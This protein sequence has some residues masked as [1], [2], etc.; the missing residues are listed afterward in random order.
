MNP[1]RQR[2]WSALSPILETLED[3]TTVLDYGSGDG[4]FTRQICDAGLSQITALEVQA[5]P[6][7]CFEPQLF[8]GQTIP[9]GDGAFDLVYS[10]D[11][12]HHCPRPRAQLDELLRVCGRYLLLK[13]H[14]YSAPLGK[15]ALCAM[16]ELGNRRFGV[17]SLYR[18]QRGWEWARQIERA[19]FGL[20]QMIH[21][22]PV[23]IGVM[24]RATNA[25]QWIGLWEKLELS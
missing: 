2:V 20:R 16:D 5:R 4:W 23:H 17:P 15:L 9:F 10:V 22:A 12:L 3:V 11:V 6:D 25:L 18:Y 24:G 7:V 14:T 21:P 13:D 1:Y 19:G 8:D